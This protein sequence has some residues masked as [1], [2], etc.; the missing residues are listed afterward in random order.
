MILLADS[1]STKTE[2]ALIKDDKSVIKFKTIGLNPVF[3]ST[4][5]V[6]NEIKL[7]ELKK[8]FTDVNYVY[9]FGAGCSTVVRQTIILDALNK[10]F[11]NAVVKVDSDLLGAGISQLGEGKGII[12]ILGTG[13]NTG[14]YSNGEI[15]ENISSL[16]YILGDEGSGAVIGKAFVK[17]FLNNELPEIISQKFIKKYNYNLD[18]IIAKVYKEPFPNRFLAS[19]MPFVYE[20]KNDNIVKNML[21]N[22]FSEF[23]EKTI[24]KYNNYQK[25]DFKLIGSIAFYF[26][27]I[28]GDICILKG[29][30]LVSVSQSPLNALVKYY[31][32]KH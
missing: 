11:I 5:D 31:I 9:F 25:Y 14:I 7:T 6:V 13:S 10:L 17:L 20:N 2:W 21:Y 1:G 3:V 30:N 24:C 32:N 22:S 12:G 29:I 16:G 27:D 26:G 28:I 18:D 23:F 4:Q 15:V 8:Y 19:F